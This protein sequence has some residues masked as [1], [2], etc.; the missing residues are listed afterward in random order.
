MYFTIFAD[1]CLTYTIPAPGRPVLSVSHVVRFTPRT[2]LVRVGA[3]VPPCY[4]PPEL[5]AVHRS[6]TALQ[7]QPRHVKPT[8][9]VP[10]LVRRTRTPQ[11][12]LI[13]KTRCRRQSTAVPRPLCAG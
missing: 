1:R 6:S 7:L 12:R 9:F 3:C 11:R 4:N 13:Q 2:L 8:R 10:A 5:C